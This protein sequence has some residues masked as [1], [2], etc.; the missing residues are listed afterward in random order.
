MEGNLCTNEDRLW[1]LPIKKD[2]TRA[3]TNFSKIISTVMSCCKFGSGLPFE[4]FQQEI[5][6]MRVP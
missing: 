6:R 2:S 3:L 1:R 4:K 5:Q